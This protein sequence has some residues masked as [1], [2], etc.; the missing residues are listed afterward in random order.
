MLF[1]RRSIAWL[2]HST[3][4]TPAHFVPRSTHAPLLPCR[5]GNFAHFLPAELPR[6]RPQLSSERVLHLRRQAEVLPL[7]IIGTNLVTQPL[8]LLAR[9]LPYV[10]KIA[11]RHHQ[12]RRPDQMC[13]TLFT[14][15]IFLSLECK[16]LFNLRR[17]TQRLPKIDRQMLIGK[18]LTGN[19]I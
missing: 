13:Q 16:V 8:Q 3:S 11:L 14:S 7:W 6:T 4:P 1:T 15:S 2:P 10:G 18:I 12:A 9:R 17:L 5:K 19:F